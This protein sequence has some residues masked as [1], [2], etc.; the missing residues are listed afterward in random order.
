MLLREVQ[1]PF[2]KRVVIFH[3]CSFSAPITAC[4]INSSFFTH[5]ANSRL[6]PEGAKSYVLGRITGPNGTLIRLELS[7]IK[8]LQP[9]IP[10][11]QNIP[12]V[13]KVSSN[14][15]GNKDS[16]RRRQSGFDRFPAGSAPQSAIQ[17]RWRISQFS[18]QEKLTETDP[19]CMKQP[20]RV[21]LPAI[22]ASRKPLPRSV[23]ERA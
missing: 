9:G 19:F 14:P 18:L 8:W 20:M 4:W 17:Y 16:H 22:T 12:R 1:S 2:R 11:A 10:F 7:K 15:H 6:G 5:C 3:P 21:G 13:C 23:E